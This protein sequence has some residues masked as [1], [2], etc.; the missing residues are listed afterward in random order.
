MCLCVKLNVVH[1]CLRLHGGVLQQLH[2][3]KNDKF[4]HSH[5]FLLFCFTVGDDIVPDGQ[6]N[7]ERACRDPSF[8]R[9]F[10]SRSASVAIFQDLQQMFPVIALSLL[11]STFDNKSVTVGG[12]ANTIGFNRWNASLNLR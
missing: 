9:H 1:R 8:T 11:Y 6:R 2:C 4:S 12:Y 3:P 10:S 7:E 5:L